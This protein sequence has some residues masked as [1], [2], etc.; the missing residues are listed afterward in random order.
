MLELGFIFSAFI[1]GVLM[2]LAPCTLPIIPAYLGFISG[3]SL[4]DF[5]S[6][7]GAQ[8]TRARRKIFFNG[9]AFVLGFTIVFVLF[10]VLAGLL[11][12]FLAPVRI[13]LSRI[14]GVAIIFFGLFM[15]GVFNL[16]F[17][18]AQRRFKTPSFLKVGKEST[19]FFI[20]ALFAFGWTPCVGPILAS[21]LFLA[22]TSATALYGGFLL[23]V[24]SL[25]LAIPF[26]L[27]ALGISYASKFIQKESK[28]L[29]FVSVIAG[30]FLIGIGILLV[31]DNFG[32]TIQYGYKLFEFIQYERLLDY[33]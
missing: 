8:K 12:E 7:T 2:F 17:L 5:E 19:S 13:W 23:L 28:Y 18:D 22:S 9:L 10:G 4:K 32:L 33:L 31:T 24:F 3:V 15:L 26:L 30:V 25:G 27:V 29:K 1:A 6:L 11:G 20:G 21:I 16:K 14:G